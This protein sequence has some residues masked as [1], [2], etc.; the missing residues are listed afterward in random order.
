M[1]TLQAFRK[2]KLPA[3]QKTLGIKNINAVPRLD[4]VIV[5]VGI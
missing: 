1:N 3:L 4:K 2:N 5:A